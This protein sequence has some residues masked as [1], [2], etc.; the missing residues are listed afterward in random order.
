M[1]VAQQEEEDRDGEV[2]SEEPHLGQHSLRQAGQPHHHAG[3]QCEPLVVGDVVVLSPSHGRADVHVEGGRD[4]DGRCEAQEEE[5]GEVIHHELSHEKC[6]YLMKIGLGVKS[7]SSSL[8]SVA[9][10]F[11]SSRM[12]SILYF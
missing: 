1:S 7:M 5:E 2:V 6:K 4:Q 11:I 8:L 3:R 12:F 9:S 10:K